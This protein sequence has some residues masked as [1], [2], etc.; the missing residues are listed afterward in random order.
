MEP[1]T[2]KRAVADHLATILDATAEYIRV[3]RGA[4]LATAGASAPVQVSIAA[5]KS[6]NHLLPGFGDRNPWGQS[7][8]IYVLQPASGELE[9]IVLTYGGRSHVAS[10]PKFGNLMAPSAAALVGG[11]G[12]FIPSGT[13]P[14]QSANTLEGAFGGWRVPLVGTSIPI[15]PPGHVGGLSSLRDTGTMDQDFLYRVAVPGHP[16]LNAMQTE[17]DMT[18]HPFAVCGKF[19]LKSTRSP[20][21]TPPDSATTPPKTG[22][23]STTPMK[24]CTCAI[25]GIRKSSII[26]EIQSVWWTRIS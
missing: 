24:V 13:I 16:E 8:G 2:G 21:S 5:L 22:G 9:G 3:N 26:P 15:P 14:G 1:R 20:I 19:N 6:G 23:F 7:Y 11:A 18:N 10:R 17:L 4:L 25:T 12:G